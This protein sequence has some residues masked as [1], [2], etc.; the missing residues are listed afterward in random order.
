MNFTKLTDHLKLATDRLIGFKPE[1]Y[2]LHEGHGVAT[3]SIYKMVDQFQNDDTT[4]F[5]ISLKAGG[6]GLNLTSAQAVIHYD[7]WWNM[8]A[9]NQATDRAHRIGQ[10]ETVQVFS[11]IMKN[12]IEEKIMEL[13]MQK[14]NLADTFVEGN[15]GSITG[16]SLEDMK[17]LFEIS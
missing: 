6:S 12:T 3:E 1:P 8:S 14:K 4:L 7:P 9:K 17:S 16:M 13:Q 2:E 11:L 10:Q 15:E 5:L